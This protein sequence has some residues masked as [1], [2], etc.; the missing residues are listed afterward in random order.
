M[1]VLADTALPAGSSLPGA[2]ATVL[3]RLAGAR[4]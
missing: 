1:F 2:V 4:S 3:A